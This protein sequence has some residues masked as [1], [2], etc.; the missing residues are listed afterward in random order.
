MSEELEKAAKALEGAEITL[1]P[2]LKG[3][4]VALIRTPSWT[5]DQPYEDA[6][7]LQNMLDKEKFGIEEV[8]R[9]KRI[10]TASRFR[11]RAS[12]AEKT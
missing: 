2:G 11:L 8:L 5:F 4:V 10:C 12:K 7:F 9:I 6:A 1:S 3:L